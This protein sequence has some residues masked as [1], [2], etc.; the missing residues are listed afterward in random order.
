MQ[1]REL[2]N[3]LDILIECRF[4]FVQCRRGWWYI[5][6]PRVILLLLVCRP[7]SEWQGS[8]DPS[9]SSLLQG[10]AV[11][12]LLPILGLSSWP[13]YVGGKIQAI[14]REIPQALP[15]SLPTYQP[16]RPQ[17][18]PFPLMTSDHP[19]SHDW[20]HTRMDFCITPR[21]S[22]SFYGYPYTCWTRALHSEVGYDSPR[23]TLHP[24]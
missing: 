4:W 5:H 19:C 22:L 20:K 18:P 2:R 17:H 1:I 23:I 12:S 9:F 16:S 8:R 11:Q 10:P 24:P 6:N 13:S 21:S 3:H 14:S 7:H 15:S